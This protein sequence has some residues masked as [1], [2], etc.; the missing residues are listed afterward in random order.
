MKY[1]LLIT[2]LFSGTDTMT[3]RSEL[4]HGTL[5]ACNS[6]LAITA[7]A[8]RHARVDWRMACKRGRP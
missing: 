3:F 8:M 4:N 2:L 1:Y 7:N 5:R 6:K